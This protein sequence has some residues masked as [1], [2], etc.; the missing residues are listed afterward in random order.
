M[1]G[2]IRLAEV[3]DSWQCCDQGELQLGGTREADPMHRKSSVQTAIDGEFLPEFHEVR[4]EFERNFTERGEQGAACAIYIHGEKVVDLWGGQRCATGG[5]P[6]KRNT[7]ALVF[8]VSKGMA[9]AAFAVAHSR[10]LFEL[11]D[12]VAEHWPAF[13]QAGKRHITIRQLLA[14]QAGLIEIDRTLGA[15]ELA[16]PEALSEIL[17]RQQPA[18]RPGT[19]HGY[20]TLTLGWYQSELLRRVDPGGRRLGVF[21]QEEVAEP[22]QA[23]F[24]IGLPNHIAEHQLARTPGWH[25]TAMLWHLHELPLGM[26]LSGMWPRSLVSR[27]VRALPLKNPAHIGGPALRHVEIPS[28]NGFGEAR[29]IARI[30]GSLATGGRELGI[31]PK[32][33]RELVA[34]PSVPDGGSRD[35]ILKIDTRY[36]FGFSRPS[37]AM[38]FGSGPKAFGCPGAGGSF[39]MAD[40]HDG[41]GFAYV[42]N[43]MGFRLFDDQRE[44]AV[45]DAC[46]R[47]LRKQFLRRRAA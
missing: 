30:Y 15:K 31:S 20:H 42:T 39:G 37:H 19:M 8:S 35:A 41:L 27:S 7:L 10:G 2:R 25:R 33:W 26:V 5:L 6:W 22:L 38:Q 13:Q 28:A 23:A 17:A 29:A 46:Y 12:P 36:G 18:W 45:R 4:S 11:D 1:A 40:P 43:T 34:P 24:Y 44:K 3:G 14:H 47:S 21:F 32:T 16:D 9:A